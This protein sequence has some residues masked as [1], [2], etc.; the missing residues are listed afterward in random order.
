MRIGT[1]SSERLVRALEADTKIAITVP[2]TVNANGGNP[3]INRELANQVGKAAEAQIRGLVAREIR[4][5]M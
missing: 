3:A 4:T 1:G 5:Q 2:V